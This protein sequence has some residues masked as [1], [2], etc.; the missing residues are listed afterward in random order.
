MSVVAYLRGGGTLLVALLALGFASTRLRAALV[1]TWWG[2]VARLAEIVLGLSILTLVLEAL[3]TVGLLRPAVVVVAV[4]LV[5]AAIGRWA[6]SR[7]SPAPAAPARD[8]PRWDALVAAALVVVVFG[9][10]LAH[11][12]VVLEGGLRDM[13]SLRYHGPFVARWVQQHSLVHLEH[14]SSEVQETF[15]PANA[16]LLHAYGVLLFGRDVLT[17]FLN[18]GWYGLGVLAAWSAPTSPRGRAAAVAGFAAICSTPLLAS[19]EPGSAKTDLAAAVLVLCAAAFVL[20][21]DRSRRGPTVLIGLAAGLAVGTKLTA[22]APV[23]VLLVGAWWVARGRRPQVAAGLVGGTALTGSFWYLRNLAHA[24]NP[25]PWIHHL[26]P[27]P[28][29]GPA[30]PGPKTHG[31]SI[32]HYATDRR[33]WTHVVPSGLEQSFGPLFPLLLLGAVIVGVLV[34]ADRRL[35]PAVRL[36]GAAVLVG[37]AAYLVTPYSA[38]GADGHPTLFALDLRFLAP[39]LALA[40]LAAGLSRMAT[41]ALAAA[42]ILVV[43]DQWA[44]LGRWPVPDPGTFRGLAVLGLLSVL[45][46]LAVQHLRGR[47][48]VGAGLV[49]VATLAAAGWPVL[50]DELGDRYAVA[51]SGLTA[52]FA[53]FHDTHGLRIAVGGFADD[54]PL[55]GAALENHVQFVGRTQPDGGFRPTRSCR[56]WRTALAVGH[57]DDVVLGRSPLARQRLPVEVAWTASDPAAHLV[58]HRGVVRVYRLRGRPDPAGCPTT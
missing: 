58:L 12:G 40:A 47:H 44:G 20:R 24:G 35:P 46:V 53:M 42:A 21:L 43:A 5:S 15:F 28:L 26:G 16:E 56:E 29:P 51:T 10:W 33:F 57:Y 41:A 32:L 1:P 48:L 31:F 7:A 11:V 45:A 27:I 39:S 55:Y 18:L 54:Y 38:G 52:A 34:A 25:L 3:G 37:A 30:M 49:L 23:V 13:D 9:Q 17:P 50:A 36:V 22:L 4:P 8:R 2:P 14:T 6:G 19:I